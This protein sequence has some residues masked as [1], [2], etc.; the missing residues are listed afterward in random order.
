[1]TY[2]ARSRNRQSMPTTRFLLLSIVARCSAKPDPFL[3][4]QDHSAT[5]PWPRHTIGNGSQGADRTRIFGINGEVLAVIATG[6]GQG[7]SNSSMFASRSGWSLTARRFASPADAVFADVDVDGA[8]DVVSCCEGREMLVNV[9]WDP[10]KI[11]N[12]WTQISGRQRTF[13]SEKIS[14]S[15]CSGCPYRSTVRMGSTSLL[16]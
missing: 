2:F 7:G 13:R 8:F 9:H 1:M 3:W 14:R 11:T 12:T 6:W 15:G 5:N 16:A 10:R 4:A